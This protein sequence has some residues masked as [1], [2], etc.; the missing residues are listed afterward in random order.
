M[1]FSLLVL[2]LLLPVT[3]VSTTGVSDNV[4]PPAELTKDD[5]VS[6]FGTAFWME[7][8]FRDEK[9]AYFVLLKLEKIG[10]LRR[11]YI[12]DLVAPDLTAIGAGYDA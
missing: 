8:K 2:S 3:V 10:D 4:F 6:G 5:Y 11:W 12:P 9:P 7:H 1:D